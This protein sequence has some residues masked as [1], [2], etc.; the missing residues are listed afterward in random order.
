M[1]QNGSGITGSARATCEHEPRAAHRVCHVVQRYC[2]PR[3]RIDAR[4]GMPVPF[5]APVKPR[6]TLCI[7]LQETR[8]RQRYLDL[9]MNSH[10]RGIFETRTRIIS[11]IRRFFD[12]RGFLEARTALAL[13]PRLLCWRPKATVFCIPPVAWTCCSMNA[14]CM[15]CRSHDML[16]LMQVETPMMN[17]IAGGATARPFITHHHDLDM[18]VRMCHVGT[19]AA[20]AVT[21]CCCGVLHPHVPSAC[22]LPMVSALL[23]AHAVRCDPASACARSSSCGLSPELLPQL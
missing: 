18:Q 4:S 7:A 16:G 9:I 14:R 3:P 10:V 12:S 23:H 15:I 5:A 19:R 11:F 22:L 21:V 8:Y 13:G 20:Q 6:L 17:M 1:L 2:V